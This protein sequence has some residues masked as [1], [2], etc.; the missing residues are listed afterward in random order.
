[1]PADLIN[2]VVVGLGLAGA[3]LCKSLAASLPATHRVVAITP[4]EYGYYPVASLRAAVVRLL[5]YL[6]EPVQRY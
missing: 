4:H 3:P 2:V 6:V 5:L 1:M